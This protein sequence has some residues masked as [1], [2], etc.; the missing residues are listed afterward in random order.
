MRATIIFVTLITLLYSCNTSPEKSTLSKIEN[1]NNKLEA[2][3]AD[4]SMTIDTLL[5]NKEYQSDDMQSITKEQMTAISDEASFEELLVNERSLISDWEPIDNFRSYSGINPDQQIKMI[6]R[7]ASFDRAPLSAKRVSTARGMRTVSLTYYKV[8]VPVAFH[9]I[10]N[11]K[12]EG[13]LSNMTAKIGDQINLLNKVYNQFN[14]AFKLVSID[15]TVND[16]W[17]TNASYYTD[18]NAL[19]QMTSTL[20][21]TPSSI[22]NVYTLGSQKVL[23]E[24]TYPWYDE[25][26]TS[27]D[28]VVINYNTLPGGPGTFFEGKYNQGKTLV[29]EVGHFL[30]LF[31][32]FEGGDFECNTNPPHDG[33]SIGD[34]VDD[35]PNQLVCYF[36]G[37]NENLDSCPTP[38]KDPVKNFMGYNP[39]ACMNEMTVG[40]GNRLLQSIITFRYYLVSN[41]I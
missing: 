15:I 32:T 35:T 10:T 37:C 3:T 27:G 33:C 2:F 23:G 22:M 1:Y 39:D 18:K 11:K 29:H 25:K 34:Q 28:Y 14:I 36:E 20:S 4:S 16:S 9:I 12:G 8:E 19:N 17:F 24:A 5:I 7:C 38:G 41:P 13:Q 6:R 30:G 26:G 21:K 40:Q 31:H